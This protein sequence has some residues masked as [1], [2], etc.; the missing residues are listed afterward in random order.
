MSIIAEVFLCFAF[1]R[2]VTLARH[3]SHSAAIGKYTAS[4]FPPT[5]TISPTGKIAS[6]HVPLQWL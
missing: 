6:E 2:Q 1:Y 3:S 4:H 5:T